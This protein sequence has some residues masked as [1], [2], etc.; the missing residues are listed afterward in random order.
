[1]RADYISIHDEKRREEPLLEKRREE[2]EPLL[3]KVANSGSI[4]IP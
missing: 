4:T 2:V 1:M 3:V